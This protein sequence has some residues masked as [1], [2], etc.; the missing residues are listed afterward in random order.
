MEI[1]GFDLKRVILRTEILFLIVGFFS[2]PLAVPC[3]S[4]PL[5]HKVSSLDI[6]DDHVQNMFASDSLLFVLR[7]DWDNENGFSTNIYHIG[8]LTKPYLIGRQNKE[9]Y[10]GAPEFQNRAAF[11]KDSGFQYPFFIVLSKD[12]IEA[13]HSI[14]YPNRVAESNGYYFEFRS[15][16]LDVRIHQAIAPTAFQLVTSYS[17]SISNPVFTGL[18]QVG[19]VIDLTTKNAGLSYRRQKSCISGRR[20]FR[21]YAA[22]GKDGLRIVDIS[23]LLHP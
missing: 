20:R 6:H 23:N 12:K 14:R 2:L 22:N 7:A 21:S 16:D 13:I 1:S 5:L 19:E 4:Q 15:F 10:E 8:D 18:T 17:L 11:G 3:R 9:T